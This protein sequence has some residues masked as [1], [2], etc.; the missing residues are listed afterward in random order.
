M[1]II[2]T[3]LILLLIITSI[4]FNVVIALDYNPLD[5]FSDLIEYN[6]RIVEL[7][8][9]V[10]SRIGLNE[11][12][13]GSLATESFY[14][15]NTAEITDLMGIAGRALLQVEAYKE[16]S[17]SKNISEVKLLTLVNYPVNLKLSEEIFSLGS[18]W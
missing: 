10:S 8:T 12:N 18:F 4:P 14:F 13:F 3:F 9:S 1:K 17:R 16:D 7:D 15:L 5:N 6:L 2:S 11:L